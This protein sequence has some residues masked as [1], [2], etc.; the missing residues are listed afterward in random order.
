MLIKI[1]NATLGAVA[2][3]ISPLREICY[4]SGT[5]TE[6]TF[7]NPQV[8]QLTWT[9]PWLNLLCSGCAGSTWRSD[10]LFSMKPLL[11]FVDPQ[12][13]FQYIIS[14]DPP[15]SPV[16]SMT[17]FTVNR[18][19]VR[20]LRFAKWS[21]WPKISPW[22]SGSPDSEPGLLTTNPVFFLYALLVVTEFFILIQNL[23]PWI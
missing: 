14:W 9:R 20:R 7:E 15:N 12:S 6:K 2:A 18:F 8:P 13:I 23:L 10:Q 19:C 16:V 5:L 22:V 1:V 21:D 17:D 4:V 11:W 3:K